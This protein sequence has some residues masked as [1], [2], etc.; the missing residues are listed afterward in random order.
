[1]A[2]VSD[3]AEPRPR[4]RLFGTI[5]PNYA[6]DVDSPDLRSRERRRGHE[7]DAPAQPGQAP[8]RFR[9]HRGHSPRAGECPSG[10][11]GPDGGLDEILEHPAAEL[12]KSIPSVWDETRALP[13]SEIGEVAAFARR[14]GKRSFVVIANGPTARSVEVSLAFLGDGAHNAILIRDQTD[15]PAAVRVEHATVRAQ[16]SLRIDLRAAGGFV[17][18][19]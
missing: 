4:P 16:D 17:A 8:R 9:D 14:H 6:W 11:F 13:F 15:E 5:L 19:I 3:R 12:I 7:R 1:V 10:D 18:R 2:A